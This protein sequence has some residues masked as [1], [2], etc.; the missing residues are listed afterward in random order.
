M[1]TLANM[2]LDHLVVIYQYPTT[3]DDLKNWSVNLLL[4]STTEELLELYGNPATGHDLKDK[5]IDEISA[6]PQDLDER[7]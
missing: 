1:K 4:K 5:I 6:L 2:S 3:H 7:L